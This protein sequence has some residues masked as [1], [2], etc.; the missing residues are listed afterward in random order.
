MATGLTL[1]QVPGTT[2]AS[3]PIAALGADAGLAALV[4]P[5]SFTLSVPEASVPA[6]MAGTSGGHQRLDITKVQDIVL[7]LTYKIT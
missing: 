6:A 4:P 2:T 5:G 1:V 7:V 3:A